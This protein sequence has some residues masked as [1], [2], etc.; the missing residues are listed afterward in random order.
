MLD[1]EPLDEVL[2]K[3]DQGYAAAQFNLGVRYD[4]GEGVP[5]DDEE[6]VRWYRLAADQGDA[7]A[8]FNLGTMYAEGQGVPQDY[9][10]RSPNVVK[11][12]APWLS[13]LGHRL[14]GGTM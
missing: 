10:T 9:V 6:A 3:A 1:D 7:D 12:L 5:Q 13:G 11:D 4:E 2:A 14:H 8:Q